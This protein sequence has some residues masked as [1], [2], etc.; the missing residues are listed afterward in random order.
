MGPTKGHRR[1]FAAVAAGLL[2]LVAAARADE[3]GATKADVPAATSEARAAG[4]RALRSGDR[5]AARRHLRRALE[6]FPQSPLILGD[7]LEASADD[8]ATNA[9]WSHQYVGSIA[10]KAGAFKAPKETA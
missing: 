10:D 9:W 6:D 2:A 3:P 8:P 1:R 7:L 5:P 4:L